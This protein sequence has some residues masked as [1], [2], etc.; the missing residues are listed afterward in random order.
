MEFL[1]PYVFIRAMHN[2]VF[3]WEWCVTRGCGVEDQE[4]KKKKFCRSETT[5]YLSPMENY[6]SEW[7]L[8]FCRPCH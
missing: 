3:L 7:N 5:L 2:I 1:Y 8:S 4:K 6:F